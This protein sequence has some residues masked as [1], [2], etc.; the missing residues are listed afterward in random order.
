VRTACSANL[1][2]FDLITNNIWRG[3][4][5]VKLLIMHVS[6]ATFTSS[7]LDSLR[8]KCSQNVNFKNLVYIPASPV[9]ERCC[10]AG[11]A[12]VPKLDDHM[13]GCPE[14]I[15]QIVVEIR[16]LSNLYLINTGHF[17]NLCRHTKL[18]KTIQRMAPLFPTRNI[19]V[20]MYKE[21]AIKSSPCTATFNDL[22]C[23]PTQN[24]RID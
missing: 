19:R 13:S 6:P 16:L 14:V 1:I 11:T 8:S 23:F 24:P 17:P 22:L 3:V 21:W 4:K 7:L 2:L 18:L 10:R 9:C 15:S 5:V 20:C 12:H